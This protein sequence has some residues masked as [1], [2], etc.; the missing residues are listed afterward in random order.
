MIMCYLFFC[1]DLWFCKYV[2]LCMY[3]YVIWLFFIVRGMCSGYNMV[4]YK[5]INVDC[6]GVSVV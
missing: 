5:F 1:G 6:D 2:Y 3:M 4:N